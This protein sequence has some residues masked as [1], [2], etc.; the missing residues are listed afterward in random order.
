MAAFTYRAVDARGRR[1]AGVIDASSAAGARAM[2]RERAL[3][4]LS[5]EAGAER[6]A[7]PASGGAQ[8]WFRPRVGAKALALVTRQLS[9][10]IGANVRVEEA[11]R[12]VARESAAQRVGAVLL[13]VRQAILDGRTFAEALGDFPEVFSELYRASIAAGEQAG[14]LDAV[15]AHL[16]DFVEARQRSAQ[17]V[18]LAML[19][20]ALLTLVS[21]GII[22]LLLT[23]VVPDIVRA[24]VSRGA[25]LPLLTRALIGLSDWINSY[26]LLL[27]GGIALA[28]LAAR[29]WL[30]TP[31]NRL[32][33]HR[34]LA[35]NPPSR[36]LS[37]RLNAAQFAGTLATLLQS[38]VPLMEALSA[39]ANVTPNHFVRARIA[40]ATAQVREGASLHAALAEADCLPPML[41]AMVA[42]G[43]GSGDLGQ[44]LARSAAD[45]QRELDSWVATLVAL[46]EPAILLLMGGLV[47]LLV[48]A[49]LLPIV[50]LNDLAGV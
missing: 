26:G 9:T 4:P 17:T 41:L 36:G 12:I 46:V 31:A 39:A 11:L 24:F 34:F 27:V 48:L 16:A 45:Q 28:V 2:L 23:Y 35:K 43:E 14:R 50:G 38:G 30:A 32:A 19:Y 5:V 44:V 33:F 37:L 10:L 8:R 47:L 3:L 15:L 49:I 40:A 22:T 21:V 29:R 20:P 13:D 18:R 7:S 6:E 25:D 42:S 1:E